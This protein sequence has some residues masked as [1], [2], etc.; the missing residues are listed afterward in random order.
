MDKFTTLLLF[1]CYCSLPK[2]RTT[3]TTGISMCV[4]TNL[5]IEW[6]WWSLSLSPL[7]WLKMGCSLELLTLT[8]PQS[9]Y[10]SYMSFLVSNT[11]SVVPKNSSNKTH[12]QWIR[13]LH[14]MF[15]TLVIC[16]GLNAGAYI[17]CTGGT[18]P[19]KFFSNVTYK[20]AGLPKNATFSR[21]LKTYML[22]LQPALVHYIRY[23][24]AM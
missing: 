1:C 9:M 2:V 24:H 14:S 13:G 19:T 20:T 5:I 10:T 15:K 11:F 23:L 18:T 7:V 8:L 6:S 22:F 17:L 3:V 12:I 21:A 16:T 4:V